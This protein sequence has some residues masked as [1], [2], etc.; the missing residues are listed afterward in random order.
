MATYKKI[1]LM[2]GGYTLLDNEDWKTYSDK[3]WTIRSGYAGHV[4]HKNNK[5]TTL[6]LH[7]LIMEAK[8]GQL[9]DHINR[10]KLDNRRANLRF[11]NRSENAANCKVHAHNTSGYKG[12]SKSGKKW[13]AYIVLNDKQIYIGTFSKK[14]DAAL[15]YNERALQIFGQFA[16]INEVF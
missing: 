10:D 8:Q 4:F 11:A 16:N 2:T 9:V 13:R 7:R 14:E 12:V 1:K 6:L 3:K 15:A 5:Q